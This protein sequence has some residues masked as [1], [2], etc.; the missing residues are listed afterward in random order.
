MKFTPFDE[1][2][3]GLLKII[4]TLFQLNMYFVT[5][6]RIQFFSFILCRFDNICFKRRRIYVFIDLLKAFHFLVKTSLFF[7]KTKNVLAYLVYID[8]INT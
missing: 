5:D 3:K 2:S 8:N 6:F 4:I 7:C 1:E